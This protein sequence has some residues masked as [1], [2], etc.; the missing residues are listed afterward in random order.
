MPRDSKRLVDDLSRAVA[1]G[2]AID[3]QQAGDQLDPD[4][5][6]VLDELRVVSEVARLHRETLAEPADA[7]LPP[8]DVLTRAV[9]GR[10]SRLHLRQVIGHGARGMVYRA[11]DPQ[12]DREVALKLI[13]DESAADEVIA[14]AR[15]MARVHHPNVATIYG[16][17][18]ADGMA[19]LWMELVEGQTLESMLRD[20]NVCSARE[21]ALIG[22]DVCAALAAVHKAGL[23]HR[24][25][26]AQNVMRDRTGRVVLTD[27]GTSRAQAPAPGAFTYDQVGTP[28]YMAPELLQGRAASVRSDIYSVGVLL[29]RLVTGGVPVE[30]RSVDELKEAHRQGTVRRLSDERSDLPLGFI[31]I[32]ER[33]LQPDPALRPASAGA[34][35]MALAEVLAPGTREGTRDAPVDPGSPL[36]RSSL[37]R[38]TLVLGG[39]AA[40]ALG[41]AGALHVAGT[42]PPPTEVRFPLYPL[43]S[44][45][46]ESLAIAPHGRSVAYVSAGQLWVRAF[47]RL[48]PRPVADTAGARDPFWSP[49]GQSIAFF[50][51]SSVWKVRAAGGEPQVLAPARRPS[52]G[53]W[54]PDG[55][56][57]LYSVDL[58]R[59]LVSVPASG[60]TPD[61]VRHQ[62]PGKRLSL[63]W[64]VWLP[65]GQAFVYSALDPA[66][67]RRA[68]V[69]ARLAA[70]A[71]EDRVLLE[72]E[73]NVQVAGGHLFFVRL[74]QLMRQPFREDTGTLSGTPLVVA[75]HV[76]TNPYNFGLAGVAVSAAGTV[77]YVAGVQ[78]TRQ[79]ELVDRAGRTL[80][81][82]GPPAEYRDIALSPDGRR[83]AFEEVDPE[84]GTRDIWIHDMQRGTR[85]RLT[86]DAA[87]EMAPV[88]APDSRT[89]YF[90]STRD[91]ALTLYRR[92]ADSSGAEAH[93]LTFE[94]PVRPYAISPD[95]AGLYYEQLDQVGGWDIW[96]RP[97]AGGAPMPFLQS[98]FNDHEARPSP[99]DRF[100]AYSSPD[101]VGRQVYLALRGESLRRWPVSTDYGREPLWRA[102]GRELFFHGKDRQ[103][104]A[105]TIGVRNGEPVI[106]TPRALFELRFRG[107]DLRYHYAALPDGQSFVLNAPVSGSSALPATIIVNPGWAR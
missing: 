103:L 52:S 2:E 54:S 89:V 37:R 77:G 33:A 107:Y 81:H 47:D 45:E 17:E 27:F 87:D 35:E 40:A 38:A 82:L 61:V 18:R 53:S 10:W 26:K 5:R 84:I 65:S 101:A 12:L 21:A 13:A 16:A 9:A 102:D 90:L 11:W 91:Q 106:G 23:L 48:D 80:Q 97:L 34:L 76:R 86:Q 36:R 67:G 44:H 98:P 69:H 7:A 105:V 70:P 25:V 62:V 63:W 1:D 79:L 41:A 46:I 94:A 55:R 29:Y 6:A 58:G 32:V 49:D 24:D 59:A 72:T 42:P 43:P 100:V 4:A 64:P 22:I 30:A 60:G 73:G 57:L 50:K 19:G 92:A 71:E 68:L 66:S 51:G 8:L 88:W 3:W 93:V 99:D 85:V 56:T 20:G 95:G 15:Q 14:E 74:G 28:L 96:W 78:Q 83:L 39:V 104:M 31:H 75:D